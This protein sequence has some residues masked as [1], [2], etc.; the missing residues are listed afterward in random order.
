M[1]KKQKSRGYKRYIRKQF[2]KLEKKTK[3]YIENTEIKIDLSEIKKKSWKRYER[4][5]RSKYTQKSILNM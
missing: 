2:R 5:F 1:K 3:E 4:S